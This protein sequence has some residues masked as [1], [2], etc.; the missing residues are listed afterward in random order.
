MNKTAIE[1]NKYL[2]HQGKES[3]AYQWLGAHPA[4]LDGIN[5]HIFRVWAPKAANVFLVGDFNDWDDEC[6]P[7]KKISR[8]GIW[9]TFKTGLKEFDLYKY[10]VEDKDGEKKAKADPYGYHM[11]TRPGT[12]SKIY[13]I[14]GYT[15]G[16]EAWM[17]NRRRMDSYRRPVNIYEVHLG[18]WRRYEDGNF[19]SYS[20]MAEELIPYVKEMGY[21]HIELMPISEYP[22]DGSW[23]YQVSGYYAPTSRYGTPKD[24][25]AFVDACH[26][27]GIGVI[28]D[29]VAGHF[30]KDENGLYMFDGMSCYEYEDD[31]K[32]EHKEWGTMIFD[33]GKPEVRSFLISNAFYWID[34]YHIDGLRVD[35]VASMLYL[36]Y[37]RE[38]NQWRSNIYGGRENLEAIE[39]LQELNK[40]V[41]TEFPGVMMIAEESTAWPMVTMPPD[42]GGLGFNFKW[43]MGWMNDSLEYMKTDPFFRK[44]SHNKLTFPMTYAFSENYILPLSHDEVVHMKGSL[45]GKMP[46]TYEEKFAHLRTYMGYMMAHPGKK[47]LFMGG[48]FAQFAE[49][50]FEK[51]LD[52]DL[53]NIEKHKEMHK[54]IKDLNNFYLQTPALWE[55]DKS[56]EGFQWIF[57]DDYEKNILSF[58]RI[59]IDGAEII[60]ICNF[61]PV[62]R[63]K[64]PLALPES[65]YYKNVFNSNAKKYGGSGGGIKAVK[66]RE[67]TL[68]GYPYHGTIDLPPLSIVFL[69]RR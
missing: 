6:H 26:Q 66:A 65:G 21:T 35:A 10:M 25:M 23:G 11:E 20:K 19:F 48:E 64:Y 46:G 69:K 22:F 60:V 28:L 37:A 39:F 5:G 58:R 1:M 36:D 3:R 29:W 55:N 63:K 32:S 68:Y 24:F 51:E 18:S 54:Y 42:L 30:P 57:P 34:R 2:Y 9:E 49:W 31:L 13:D 61:A 27:E 8:E 62:E 45:I 17:E 59:G 40:A 52:W 4:T 47:L 12:A 14:D 33:W 56:W 38:S 53:L 44:G 16:D 7:M 67:G 15:F 50:N 43:N 41:L